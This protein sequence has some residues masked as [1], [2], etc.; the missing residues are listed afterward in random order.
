MRKTGMIAN[1]G[2]EKLGHIWDFTPDDILKVAECLI[3][4][5]VEKGESPKLKK[6]KDI[7][8]RKVEWQQADGVVRIQTWSM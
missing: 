1:F 8:L 2:N 3:L 4:Y 6:L 5:C 7:C